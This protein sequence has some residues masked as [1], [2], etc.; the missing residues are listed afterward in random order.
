MIALYTE[1]RKPRKLYNYINYFKIEKRAR[2]NVQSIRKIIVRNKMA[3][4]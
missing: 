4:L 3:I 2:I 1:T